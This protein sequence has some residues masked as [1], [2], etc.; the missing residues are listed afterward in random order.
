VLAGFRKTHRIGAEASLKYVL[1]GA[2]TSAVM[3]YGLSLLYGLY[4]TLQLYPAAGGEGVAQVMAARPGSPALLVI[5][6]LGLIVGLGFKISA[7]PF[8]FWCPD[9]FE[10]ASIDVTTFLSVASKG[11]GLVLLMRVVMA[12][13]D[14]F[15]YQ[16]SAVTASLAAVIGVL[17]AVTCTVGNT[18]AYLQTNIKRL[19]A[20]SSIAHAG[21]M[22]CA[23]SLLVVGRGAQRGFA[24]PS[25][26][27]AQAILLY[28]AVYLFMNLGAFTVA[29]VVARQTGTEQ[30][31]GFAG[32][33]RRSPVL[34]VCMAVFMISLIGLPPLA[35]FVAKVNLLRVLILDGGWWWALV[36][37]IGLN[38]IIS[39]YYYARVLRAMYLTGSDEPSF[40]GHPLG[41]AISGACAVALLLLFVGWGPLDRLTS[42]FGHLRT[43]AA[44]SAVD[45]TRPPPVPGH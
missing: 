7:V 42:T 19:L 2:V 9:V 35:G 41:L 45:T 34:A 38:T 40:I 33:G 21:Y 14:A 15:G 37:V 17:G 8:H 11:A 23:L 43:A 1:F 27:A 29:G 31:D 24:D 4:G 5:G 44:A 39:L 6:L 18:A 32:L 13:A 20:Y 12:F 30:L 25:A 22:L 3:V 28:L 16:H 26:A 10:G 36:A